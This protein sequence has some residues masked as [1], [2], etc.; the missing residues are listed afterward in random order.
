MHIWIILNIFR[1][2]IA[3]VYQANFYFFLVK[4]FNFISAYCEGI[5]STLLHLGLDDTLLNHFSPTHFYTTWKRRETYGFL[6]FSWG[7]RN[8]TLD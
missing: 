5:H 6:T 2:I 1:L 3:A 4:S 8:M 7:Y